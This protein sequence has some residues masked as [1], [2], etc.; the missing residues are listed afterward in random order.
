LKTEK[1]TIK[2]RF[3]LDTLL[4]PKEYLS[5]VTQASLAC[6]F[7]KNSFE[8]EGEYAALME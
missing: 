3:F 7:A 2:L 6:P 5:E 8:D 1:K 4:F